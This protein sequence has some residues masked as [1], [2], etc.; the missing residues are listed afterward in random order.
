MELEKEVKRIS[1]LARIK[2][3]DYNY[4]VE[5]FL[6]ILNLFK[7]INELDLE[8]EKPFFYLEHL[9]TELRKDEDIEFADRELLF[10]NSPEKKGNFF[11]AESPIELG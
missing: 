1:E 2:I 7:K 3:E 4:F 6:K 8:N 10:L 11:V 9:K 5:N